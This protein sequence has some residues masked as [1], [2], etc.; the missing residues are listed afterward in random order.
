MPAMNQ[1]T[2]LGNMTRDAELSYMPNQTAVSD[3][4]LA[5]NRQWTGPDGQKHEETCFID[6]RTFGK[7]ADNLVKYT[8][9][10]QLI[11]VVGHLAFERWEDKEHNSHSKHRL[12]AERVVFMPNGKQ[13]REPGE[14][15]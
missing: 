4:G 3:F 10:G 8:G 6:V 15:G 13:T 11:L 9:K 12:I 2:M 5:V 14:D 1:V 7:T